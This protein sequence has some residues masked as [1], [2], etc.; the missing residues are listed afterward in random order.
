MP[1]ITIDYDERAS[2]TG[3][4]AQPSGGDVAGA[5]DAGA[6]P[7]GGMEGPGGSTAG[8]ATEAGAPPEWLLEAIAHASAAAP[9][10]SSATL[11]AEDAGA[12]PAEGDGAI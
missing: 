8:D 7:A 6:A 1:R 12:A 9:S 2:G 11:G 3:E 10:G 5:I 4:G